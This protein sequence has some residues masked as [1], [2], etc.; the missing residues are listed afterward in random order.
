MIDLEGIDFKKAGGLV[1]AV[2]QHARTRQVLMVGY[3]DARAAAATRESGWVTFFSRSRNALWI[4]GETSGNRLRLVSMRA[5]CDRDALLVEAEPSGPT[6]HRGTTG[7]FDDGDAPGVGF[8]P[9]LADIIASRRGADPETSYVAR[10]L[11]GDPRKAAQKVGEEGV[12][13]AL[14]A[15]VQDDAA[16]TEEAADLI[17]HLLVALEARGVAFG[18]VVETLRQRHA[19]SLAITER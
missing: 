3:M 13:V 2:V 11:S 18:D 8:I 17:F 7:C 6:C 16:L 4:K 12:E 15:A 1:P 10:L 14:A 19:S 9:L 5:D